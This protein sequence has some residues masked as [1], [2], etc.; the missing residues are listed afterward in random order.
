[1]KSTSEILK[2]NC[3]KYPLKLAAKNL[4]PKEI[5]NRPK[6]GFGI[7]MMDWFTGNLMQNAKKDISDFCG[8]T[9]IFNSKIVST[10]IKQTNSPQPWYLMNLAMW[11]KEYVA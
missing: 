10:L 7:P 9:N 4:I 8:E 1:M 3:L 11:W 6:Q 5:I 2:N